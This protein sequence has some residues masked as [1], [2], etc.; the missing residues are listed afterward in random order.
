MMSAGF[1]PGMRSLVGVHKIHSRQS[2]S[3]S[4]DEVRMSWQSRIDFKLTFLL[5]LFH[6]VKHF[7]N[8]SQTEFSGR[9]FQSL[10]DYLF[11]P[12]SVIFATSWYHKK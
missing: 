4:H 2:I 11:P 10:M 1:N 7:C 3:D 5:I 6:I 9:F 12:N 8:L